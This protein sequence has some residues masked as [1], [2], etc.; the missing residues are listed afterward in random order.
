MFF[1]SYVY[2]YYYYYYYYFILL[3]KIAPLLNP[4][5]LLVL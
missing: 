4:L 2:Y 3:V 1:N 5:Q